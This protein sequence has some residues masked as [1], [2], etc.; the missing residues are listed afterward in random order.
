VDHA[1]NS[2][3]GLWG[4]YNYPSES[5]ERG[6]FG[7]SVSDTAKARFNTQ[8]LTLGTVQ[9]ITPRLSND[10]R[11]NYSRNR[12]RD[13]EVLDSFGGAVPPPASAVFPSGRTAQDSDFV[14]FLGGSGLFYIVGD[15]VINNLQRQ[16][17][18][19]DNLSVITG[20]HQLKFGFDYRRLS[21]VN[22]PPDY[23]QQVLF[24]GGVTQAVTG[25]A[26]LVLVQ[27]RNFPGLS[28]D[29]LSIYSQD[30]WKAARRL[31]LT[32]GLRW[33]I[34]P[35]P[36]AY[37]GF[38]K[39]FAVTGA[40]NPATLALAP[41]GTSLYKMTYGNF[42]PRIGLA[43]Q[44]S[45]RQG[46]ETIL[47]GGF[48]VFCDLGTGSLGYVLQGFPF[49]VQNIFS[50]V[51]FP[52]TP[53]QAT[54]PSFSL[55]TR[56]VSTIFAYDPNQKLPRTYQWN[57]TVEQSLG[58]NQTFSASYIGAV[59]RRLLRLE[60][61]IN[62]NPTFSQI[63]IYRND[64]TSD[65]DALQLQFRRRF[66]RGL[67]A[68]VSYTW[69]HSIDTA[70]NDSSSNVPSQIIDPQRD[71]GPSDFDIRHS[72][73][74]AVTYNPPSPTVSG[75]AKA[76]LSNWAI[77]SVFY[78]RS[79]TPVNV[80]TGTAIFGVSNVFRPNLTPG[81]PLYLSNPLAAGGKRSTTRLIRPD[82]GARVRF[83]RR[84]LVSKARSGVMRFEDSPRI[85]W[86][87]RSAASL[88]SPNE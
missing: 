61:L 72:L 20:A 66:S 55:D 10:F 8:T 32:Y 27:A 70:S 3:I 86:I 5:D 63:Q 54:P 26:N 29:N 34:N 38:A 12:A 36:S 25:I 49:S 60:T 14:F 28:L 11:A 67:Q 13:L 6:P 52:L 65:Y 48:G 39:P 57:T 4:R 50:D 58:V 79:A 37:G 71:R 47:R 23:A 68:L 1:I 16:V 87:L 35:P 7:T 84:H 59:S 74:T 51:P 83:A 44:L 30:T 76:I 77:D 15:N 69:S 56:P 9:S 33:E 46:K 42:A 41:Q 17:S 75:F 82:R 31:T 78:A 24:F 2:G 45:Q 18:L 88:A 40:D 22:V 73:S 53:L 64:A 43:Y 21:P 62:P 81:I 19:I 80:V 85:S